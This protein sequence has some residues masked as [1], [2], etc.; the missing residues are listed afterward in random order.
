VAVQDEQKE[1]QKSVVLHIGSET[2]AGLFTDHRQDDTVN[3]KEAS[4]NAKS[5]ASIIAQSL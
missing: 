5:F 3:A 1:G 4:S 2:E